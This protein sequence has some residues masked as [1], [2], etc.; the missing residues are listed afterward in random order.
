MLNV[1]IVRPGAIDAFTRRL[2]SCAFR[3]FIG[4]ILKG[5]KGSN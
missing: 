5:G 3:P 1:V 4:L 2:L